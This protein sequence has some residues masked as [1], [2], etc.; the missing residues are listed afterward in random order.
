MKPQLI[1]DYVED[2]LALLE[3]KNNRLVWGRMIALST[4]AD[5]KPREICADL[6]IVKDAIKK[7]T[8]IT[9]V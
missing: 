4:I 9:V 1:A 8:L 6:D 2:F 7:D 5:L 3:S